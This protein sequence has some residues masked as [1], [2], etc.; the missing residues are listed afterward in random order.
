[1]RLLIAGFL[2]VIS[3]P[4][5][6]ALTA[7][8]LAMKSRGIILYNQYK[9]ITAQPLLMVAAQA[10]DHEAQYY[11]AESLRSKDGY[12]NPEAEKWYEAAAAQGDLYA[13]IQLG[14]D[15]PDLCKFVND[16][17][18]RAKTPAEWLKKALSIAQ[19]QAT[20]GDAE[21]MYIM[22]ELTLDTAWLEKSAAKNHSLSQ[23][24]LATS[25]K[26]GNG[27][28][29][30]WKRSEVVENL[31]E[32]SAKGG[33]PQAMM[34][35]G[36]IRYEKGDLEGFRYWN[37]QAALAGY[38]TA[39]YGHGS[40]LAHEPDAYGFTYD[41]VKG[42]GLIYSLKEL[43]G[44]GGLQSIIDSKL[45]RIEAKMTPRQIFEAKAFATQWKETHPPLSFFP[46]KLSR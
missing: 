25:Y 46:N 31:F 33:N 35:I 5:V 9:A 42:Y 1:M 15:K 36:A 40:D 4:N 19:P 24:L 30:P 11:L 27:F 6:L 3:A 34:E 7:S 17:P 26:Q 37:E 39:V 14:R 43:N 29:L 45:P 23:Y 13:M 2:L 28:F 41:I 20:D 21:A 8:E 32:V 12:M 10:G 22:Y 44:G 18:P 16:C 38:A